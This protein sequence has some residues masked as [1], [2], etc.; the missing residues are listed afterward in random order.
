MEFY[1]KSFFLQLLPLKIN[2]Y[3]FGIYRIKQGGGLRF[4]CPDIGIF[5]L[6]M[7]ISR[8]NF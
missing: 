1:F 8:L 6:D 4:K 2:T 5:W 7:G 3:Y